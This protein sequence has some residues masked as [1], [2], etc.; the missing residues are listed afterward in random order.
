MIAEGVTLTIPS[1]RTLTVNGFLI[2]HGTIK[3]AS[4]G[5]L[6]VTGALSE[7]VISEDGSESWMSFDSNLLHSDGIIE[8]SGTVSVLDGA[9]LYNSGEDSAFTNTSTGSVTVSGRATALLVGKMYQCESQLYNSCMFTNNGAVSVLNYGTLH[10]GGEFL[11]AAGAAL[12]MDC[13]KWDGNAGNQISGDGLVYNHGVFTNLGQI[14]LGRFN[15][16]GTMTNGNGTTAASITIPASSDSETIYQSGGYLGNY[17]VF[18]NLA[19]ASVL[20]DGEIVNG[21]RSES[22]QN[23]G[24]DTWTTAVKYGTINNSGT[25]TNN[26]TIYNF[27]GCAITNSNDFTGGGTVYSENL[28]DVNILE[29]IKANSV[30][31]TWTDDGY[32]WGWYGALVGATL[33]DYSTATDSVK[34]ILLY[35]PSEVS[36]LT[37]YIWIKTGCAVTAANGDVSIDGVAAEE[38]SDGLTRYAIPLS[39]VKDGDTITL[40]ITP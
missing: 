15:N 21:P 22:T 20:N 14:L 18:N 19:G 4:G 28:S 5:T 12:T 29:T 3:V 16:Y 11:N 17:N 26:E 40:T 38:E 10:N 31:V 27:K 23:S 2:N 25:F 36:K 13:Y 7:P 33:Y 9:R 1:G 6:T 24:D 37:F 35:N 32:G 30:T 34:Y 39:G 8:N